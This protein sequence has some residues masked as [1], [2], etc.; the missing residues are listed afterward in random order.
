[1]LPTDRSFF[2]PN[3]VDRVA[4][5]YVRPD[6]LEP[7]RY[8]LLEA[9]GP[10]RRALTQP[11]RTGPFAAAELAE[12]FAQACQ[13]LY[14][15]GYLPVGC[16]ALLERLNGKNARQAAL[17]ALK[18]GWRRSDPV[19]PVLLA[20][21]AQAKTGHCPLLDALG[22][23]GDPAAILEVSR[24]VGDKRWYVRRSAVEALRNLGDAA[25]LA[26]SLRV[27]RRLFPL[28]LD[29][30]GIRDYLGS[31]DD[32]P[33]S[34]DAPG[35]PDAP[36]RAEALAAAVLAMGPA[37]AGVML[38]R[39]YEVGTPVCV[40]AV[41][42][43]LRQLPI[44]APNVWRYVKSVHKRAKLRGDAATF[45]LTAYLVECKA[46]PAS[47][48]SVKLAWGLDERQKS[49]RIFSRQTREYLLRAAW[50][51][52]RQTA[53]YRPDAYAPLA[54]ECLIHYAPDDYYR[55]RSRA[56][57]ADPARSH[58]LARLYL[59]NCIL[60]QGGSR[61]IITRRLRSRFLAPPNALPAGAREEMYPE[62][63]DRQPRAYLRVLTQAKLPEVHPF[64]VRALRDDHPEVLRQAALA[65]LLLLL[66]APYEP[67]AELGA[68]EL[69]RRFDRQAP[70][71]ALLLRILGHPRESIRALGRRWLEDTATRWLGDCA[72]TVR[73]LTWPDAP[74][75]LRVAELVLAHLPD[76]PPLRQQLAQQVLAVLRQ[77]EDPPGAHDA[78]GRVAR[79]LLVPYLV[80]MLPLAEWERLILTGSPALQWLASLVVAR[81][82]GAV[83]ELGL[84]RLAVLAQHP[85]FGVRQ[86]VQALLRQAAA[87]GQAELAIWLVLVESEWPDTRALALEMLQRLD[88]SQLGLEA[89]G[90]LLDS[91]HVEV[92]NLGRDLVL[93]YFELLPTAELVERLVQHPHR[94]MRRFALELVLQHSPAGHRWLVRLDPFLRAILFDLWPARA[95]KRQVLEFLLARGLRSPEEA[96]AVADILQA[97]ARMQ[98][99]SDAEQAL[100]SLAR[101]KLAWPEVDL[102]VRLA[103]EALK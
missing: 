16:H 33:G 25:A 85:L 98:T 89:L 100:L 34:A 92:Q 7:T 14:D 74:T 83:A 90:G 11:T 87:A 50:R 23:L 58:R 78:P 17:A 42:R 64:A 102:G 47:N 75:A 51:F 82:P 79:E 15:Q 39:L 44:T 40:A 30:L 55:P 12:P 59:L 61:L 27:I 18:L 32:A 95:D 97:A 28:P 70:D 54:A 57:A 71:L 68:R 91:N 56:E 66:D 8:V 101:L 36:D 19:V 73:L 10:S 43:A 48:A 63:W 84:E 72:L 6:P 1:M 13:R 96:L 2:N 99:R 29:I 53:R 103:P 46:R 88:W 22:M 38:D 31:A 86:A 49:V 20:K 24:W 37:S 41:H 67:T 69:D 4:V 52:L 35:S 45:G 5:L 65:E 62:C 60:F 76:E 21:L 3:V 26:S 77:P 93:Q 9:R 81:T 94:R 80:D